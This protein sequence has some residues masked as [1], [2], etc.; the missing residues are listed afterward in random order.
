[1]V[2]G[3]AARER[4]RVVVDPATRG[5]DDIVG[6]HEDI[7]ER[8]AARH[9]GAHAQHLPIV[10]QRDTWGVGRHDGEHHPPGIGR[11]ALDG[12]PHHQVLGNRGN[13]GERLARRQAI[14]TIDRG[15]LRGQSLGAVLVE[16]GLRTERSEICALDD[17]RQ[18]LVQKGFATDQSIS[19][20]LVRQFKSQRRLGRQ[21]D[22]ER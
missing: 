6:G 15:Q 8:H 12:A 14:A 1:M 20:Y 5:A 17:L 11:V 19:E 10:E 22:A 21:Q 4:T 13:R 3:V 2:G 7:F 9:R 16:V 18:I